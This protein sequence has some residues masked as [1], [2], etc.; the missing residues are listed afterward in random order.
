MLLKLRTV[1]EQFHYLFVMRIAAALSRCVYGP[2]LGQYGGE[3][4]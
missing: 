3:L 4:R 2:L 1:D